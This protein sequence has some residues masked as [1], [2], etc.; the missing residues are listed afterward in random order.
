MVSPGTF[1]SSTG[2]RVEAMPLRN[3]LA[4]AALICLLGATGAATAASGDDQQSGRRPGPAR[5]PE[6][7]PLDLAFSRRDLFYN[8]KAAVS[9]DG[10]RVAYVVVTP[11]KSRDDLWTLASGLALSLGLGE[12]P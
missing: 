12:N 5:P 6:P 4:R 10:S 2:Y 9:P 1:D 8:E 7:F 3:F 11:M